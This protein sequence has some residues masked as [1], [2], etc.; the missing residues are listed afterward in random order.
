MLIAVAIGGGEGWESA[1]DWAALVAAIVIA[2]N[3][4]RLLRPAIAGL[5]DR[6][7]PSIRE[8]YIVEYYSR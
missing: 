7:E 8:Q 1:D 2:W 6:S 3:G 5:M 4:Q